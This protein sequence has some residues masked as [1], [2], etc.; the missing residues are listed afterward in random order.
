MDIRELGKNKTCRHPWE[1][2]RLTAIQRILA[3][4]A[5]EGIRVLDVGS[6]DGFIAR[7]LFNYLEKKEITAV[8]IHIT[9]ELTQEFESFPGNIQYLRELPEEAV[10]D[11]LLLLDVLEH[12]EDDRTFLADLVNKHTVMGGM[13]LITVP[14][15]QSLFSSHD[16]FM[17][18]FRRYALRDLSEIVSADGLKV[19]LSGY[20]FLSLLLPK[21][22]LYKLLKRGKR[23]EGVGQWSQGRIVS[24]FFECLL[25]VDNY[26]L[27][28][29]CRLGIRLPGLTGWVLCKKQ[30]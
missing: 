16:V 14:A 17:K 13:V 22:V 11:L 4:F 3:P 28:S 2:A 25:H 20:L 15:F 19:I 5:F 30:Q 18:H 23:F 6:G 10:F 24:K 26:V 7:G 27:M 9:N 1:T 21:L 29:T 8:D 12:V